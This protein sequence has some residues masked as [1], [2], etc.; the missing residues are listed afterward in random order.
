MEGCRIG[1]GVCRCGVVVK[2]TL[3][4]RL[5]DVACNAWQDIG[6][7]LY[8]RESV[9]KTLLAFHDAP[10][11]LNTSRRTGGGADVSTIPRQ[12]RPPWRLQ[13]C[14]ERLKQLR[15]LGNSSR[16]SGLVIV[17]LPALS[18][19]YI[20]AHSFSAIVSSAPFSSHGRISALL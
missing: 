16:G 1:F 11:G 4:Q 19:L 14:G 17:C 20:S 18:F 13:R 3:H 2:S 5:L 8:S 6:S 12:L 9:S 7:N 15:A 10:W